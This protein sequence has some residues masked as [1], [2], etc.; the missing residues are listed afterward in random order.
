[1]RFLIAT[2]IYPP[3]IGGP[4]YYAKNLSEALQAKGHTV[5]IGTF[6]T[7]KK[8][9]TGIRHLLL[10]LKIIPEVSQ[11]DVV[12]ALD[13]FSAAIPAY[14]AARLFRKPVI[15]RTGGDFLWEQYIERTGDLL[16]LPFFYE[17]HQ[18][19]SLLERMYFSM[20]K[21]LL[22]RVTLVFSTNFQKDLW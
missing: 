13:T 19:F 11:A 6:G 8:F 12:I 10:F 20:T 2:G 4:A 17:K 22:P 3:E 21:F 1:M 9:P 16:P 18:P 14:F 15:V 7:L 5:D